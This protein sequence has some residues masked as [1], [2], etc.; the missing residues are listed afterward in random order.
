MKHLIQ[1]LAEKYLDQEAD[2]ATMTETEKFDRYGP[3]VKTFKSSSNPKKSYE[4]RR[5]KG[6]EPTCNCR[7]WATH[8]KC[9]HCD[10]V[11]HNRI[12]ASFLQ[13]VE[14][15][16]YPD[17]FGARFTKAMEIL[18]KDSA[19][20]DIMKALKLNS[21]KY[22]DTYSKQPDSV[23]KEGESKEAELVKK[24]EQREK[25]LNIK[26]APNGFYYFAGDL[27]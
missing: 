23:V 26:H 18:E 21:G 1:I 17:N 15:N 20:Q 12:A 14:A 10:D 3:I 8:K 5:K 13:K 2:S 11:K 6:Q 9:W 4:V 22:F 25:E 24:A 16:Q 19:Y 7:G 27:K